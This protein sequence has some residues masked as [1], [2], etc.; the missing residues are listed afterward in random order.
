MQFLDAHDCC[1]VKIKNAAKVRNLCR[2]STADMTE[3]ASVR[4]AI[5]ARLTSLSPEAIHAKSAAIAANL[6]SASCWRGADILLAFCSIRRE[7][8][9]SEMLRAALR[10][11]KTVGIPRMDGA[12][13]I[14]HQLERLDADF[15]MHPFG[16][17]EPAAWWPEIRV[18]RPE[19]RQ[20][21]LLTPGLAFDRSMRRL[22]RGKGFYDRVLRQFKAE[23]GSRLLAVG[24]CFA[25][26]LIER[27]PANDSD[28]PVD[29]LITDREVIGG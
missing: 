6:F 15:V 2:V 3:K 17:R 26:Q 23:C 13:L 27:V 11:G 12:N 8:D 29:L 10:E 4:A 20:I 16:I 5:N 24:V 19:S 22:G 9:T 18:N 1:Q 14:F 7:V 21:L 25:E 28:Q